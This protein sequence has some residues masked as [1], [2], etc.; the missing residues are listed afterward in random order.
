MEARVEL[1][2]ARPRA[3]TRLE[4]GELAVPRDQVMSTTPLRSLLRSIHPPP[5]TDSR[6]RAVALK[7]GMHKYNHPDHSMLRAMM[8][9]CHMGGASDNLSVVNT[10]CKYHEERRLEAEPIQAAE[11]RVGAASR[12]RSWPCALV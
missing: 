1:G 12:T 10:D 8:M 6:Y 7:N 9:V 2:S 3:V 5:P 11:Q 4:P